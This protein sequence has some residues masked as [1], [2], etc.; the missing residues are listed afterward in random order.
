MEAHSLKRYA[1][2]ERVGAFG[3]DLDSARGG[4]TFL[5]QAR[6]IL[7]DHRNILWLTAEGTFTDVRRRPVEI[8]QGL[9][10]LARVSVGAVVLPLALEYPFWNESR[11]EALCRFGEP[12][13]IRGS[14]ASRTSAELNAMF[15]RALA[16]TMEK[17]SQESIQR[18]PLGFQSL[19]KGSSGVGGVYDEWR[20]LRSWSRGKRFNAS[21]E[22]QE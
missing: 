4:V 7:A 6:R 2:F 12:F 10:Y 17:L 15:A 18:S 5:V 20:R 14:D 1:I 22:E 11:P 9:A 8:Q 3:I 16:Q 21:H 13:E 19:L